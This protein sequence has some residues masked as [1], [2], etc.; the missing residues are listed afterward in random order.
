MAQNLLNY[1]KIAAEALVRL[2]NQL[3]MAQLVHRDFSGE[4]ASFGETVQVRKP[5]T[6]TAKDFTATTDA[7]DIVET[8]VQVKMDKISDVSVEL[9]SK[10][11][12]LE[13][14]DLGEQ[15]IEGAMQALA[16]KVDEEL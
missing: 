2:E 3:V 16:Q 11:M 5:A 13:I 15:V 1:D 7:E 6:F 9:T 14:E 10:E 12:T 4:F 8:A